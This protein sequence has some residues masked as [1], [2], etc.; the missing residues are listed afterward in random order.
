LLRFGFSHSSSDTAASLVDHY[1]HTDWDESSM[2]SDVILCQ[3]DENSI[4]SC[5]ALRLGLTVELGTQAMH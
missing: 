5:F 4:D 2:D 3:M 1:L